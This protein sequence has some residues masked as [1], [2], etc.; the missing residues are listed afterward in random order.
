MSNGSLSRCT[1]NI[2]FWSGAELRICCRFREMRRKKNSKKK[3]LLEKFSFNIVENKPSEIC[4]STH[5]DIPSVRNANHTKPKSCS[6]T[7]GTAV[8][9]GVGSAVGA[10]V[11]PHV[12]VRNTSEAVPALHLSTRFP[13]DGPGQSRICCWPSG[14]SGDDSNCPRICSRKLPS[15]QGTVL[16]GVGE[17]VAAAPQVALGLEVASPSKH[18]NRI[19]PPLSRHYVTRITCEATC[20]TRTRVGRFGTTPRYRDRKYR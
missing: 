5:G 18:W 10:A 3:H 11:A 8:G 1:R 13:P 4:L 7:V 9:T 12:S 20:N 15:A 19:S 17:G 14:I 2:W 16:K 6:K